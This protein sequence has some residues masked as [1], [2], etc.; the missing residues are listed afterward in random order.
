MKQPFDHDLRGW[1]DA[2]TYIAL[3]H[4]A[5]GDDRSLS[6]YIRHILVNHL[7]QVSVTVRS[8]HRDGQGTGRDGEGRT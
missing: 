5:S 3:P 7:R 8:L 2:Q 1:V 4:L 6:E